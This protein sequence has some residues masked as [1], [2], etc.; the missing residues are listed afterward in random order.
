MEQQLWIVVSAEDDVIKEDLPERKTSVKWITASSTRSWRA[1]QKM[2]FVRYLKWKQFC[3][4][5]GK[6]RSCVL[7]MNPINYE[8]SDIDVVPVVLFESV[9]KRL[10]TDSPAV[11][12]LIIFSYLSCISV[13]EHAN[14]GSV[15]DHY[16]Y[17][18][19]IIRM[20]VPQ[21]GRAFFN[22]TKYSFN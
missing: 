12:V 4:Q 16:E 15:V 14:I 7:G 1:S 9:D 22:S 5:S 17:D 18:E 10:N 19:Q 20:L 3:F 2:N 21:W 8:S 6:V 13:T 11:D